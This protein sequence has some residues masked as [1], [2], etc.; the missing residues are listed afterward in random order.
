MRVGEDVMQTKSYARRQHTRD[1]GQH[2]TGATTDT[3]RFQHCPKRGSEG[4]AAFEKESRKHAV[5]GPTSSAER[6]RAPQIKRTLSLA[7][8]EW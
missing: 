8:L 4:R 3:G 1:Q 2:G 5:H 6:E 7:Q